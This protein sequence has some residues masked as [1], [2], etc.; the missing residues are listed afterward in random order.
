[1]TWGLI[2]VQNGILFEPL[3]VMLD[4]NPFG[5]LVQLTSATSLYFY[6]LRI[7]RFLIF[8]IKNNNNGRAVIMK[9]R[10]S[11]KIENKYSYINVNHK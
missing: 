1:M 7:Q 9:I 11:L 2:V 8:S 5:L 4:G 10:H 6:V 3:F